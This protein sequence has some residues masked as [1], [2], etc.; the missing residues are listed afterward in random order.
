[1]ASR[2]ETDVMPK[3]HEKAFDRLA[4]H[5]KTYR[6]GSPALYPSPVEAA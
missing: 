4:K 3:G 5:L 6:G 1:V 2:W